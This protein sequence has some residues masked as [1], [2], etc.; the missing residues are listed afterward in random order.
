MK[1]TRKNRPL[2]AR[3]LRSLLAAGVKKGAR[4][5]VGVSGG[6]DSTALLSILASLCP[7]KPFRLIACIVDHGIRSRGEID[8]DVDFVRDLSGSLGVEFRL[9]SVPEGECVKRTRQ[10]G[11]GLEEAARD[12]RLS[13][14]E[15]AVGD[16]QAEA[17][18]LGHT[19]DDQVETL[20]MR[21]I[22]GA[23]VEGLSGISR[24]RGIYVRPM[25]SCRRAELLR[26][27]EARGIR[28]RT[29]STNQ[30]R[31]FLRNRI[32][33][34]V[35]PALEEAFPGFRAGLAS[36]SRKLRLAK[37]FIE[38]ETSRRLQWKESGDAYRI[39]EAA[40][41]E[42]P[43]ALRAGSIL[44]LYDLT[45]GP[46]GSRRLPFSFLSPALG[47][48]LPARVVLE[49][50]GIRLARDGKDLVWERLDKTGSAT[51]LRSAVVIGGEKSYF[52]AV[53]TD[54]SYI[55][56][57]AALRVDFKKESG[58]DA[59][60][61][62]PRILESAIS[63]PLVLRSRRGGDALPMTYGRKSVKELF[64]EWKV[65]QRLRGIIPLL[66]DRRGIVA[67]LGGSFGFPDFIR[68]GARGMGDS[69]AVRVSR[70][71]S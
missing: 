40:F 18:V 32:R 41:L 27:L 20:I 19:A 16:L 38:A 52:I 5:V 49:G 22:S 28:Y 42:A 29:D 17:V 64:S 67:V 60:F 48:R 69:I 7:E 66:A 14:L 54:G 62:C 23:G 10:A 53:E 45:Q 15:R 46:K 31:R 68:A 61:F 57:G 26:Y 36:M 35:M 30:D 43:A 33:A 47:E 11:L 34:T 44:K 6:P 63:P 65:P 70:R 71:S 3:I 21:A 8:G 13:L 55:V 4:L 2:E 37:D 9:L 12:L 24:R 51:S 25:L 59:G 1:S 56:S 50:H 58:G 39:P